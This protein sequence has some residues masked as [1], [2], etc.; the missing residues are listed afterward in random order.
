MCV[1]DSILSFELLF[2]KIELYIN[3][4]KSYKCFKQDNILKIII[5]IIIFM[6]RV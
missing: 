4:K 3:Y 6:E 5:F 1:F 2:R